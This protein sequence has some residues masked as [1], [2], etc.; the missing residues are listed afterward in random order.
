VK[1][2]LTSSGFTTQTIIDR[3][4]ELVGKN[5]SDINVAVINEGYAVEQGDHSWVIEELSQLRRSFGGTIELV[6]L[7]VLDIVKVEERIRQ[8]DVIY[9]VGG[10]TD[11]LMCVYKKTGFDKL[12]LELLESKVYVGSSAGSMVVGSR[13]STDSYQKIYGEAETFGIDSYLGLVDVAIK[14]HLNSPEWPNNRENILL[15]VTQNFKGTLYGLS[16]NSAISV[17]DDALE[18]VGIDYL[19]I[20][21]GVRV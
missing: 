5:P 18:P 6:N 7:L 9:V 2:L 1:L 14:P 3:C 19:K 16:D 13:V 21:D 15:E 11:Y 4:A 17:E 20:V 10:N 12:L 8:S